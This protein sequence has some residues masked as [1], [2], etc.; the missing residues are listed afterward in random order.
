MKNL[1]LIL[2]TILLSVVS[3]QAQKTIPI[4]KES[5]YLNSLPDGED[6]PDGTYYKDV[7]NVLDKYKGVWK[8]NYKN[9]TYEL[10]IE[11]I[12][13]EFLGIK[14][15]ALL[16]SYQI[17]DGSNEISNDEIKGRGF[18]KA[19]NTVYTASYV[20][21][22]AGCGDAG[23]LFLDISDDE[24]RMPLYILPDESIINEEKCPD[25]LVTPPFPDETESPMIIT[26]Q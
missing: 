8:A 6:A 12:T 25:G 5:A 15:D 18:D 13:R 9:K 20:G 14:K 10:E 19:D 2:I 23:T 24:K 22:D 21:E 16:L 26:K 3:C 4:E 11:K 7:N 17:S 1:G